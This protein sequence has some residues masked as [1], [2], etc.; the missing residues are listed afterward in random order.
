MIE[1]NLRSIGSII[2]WWFIFFAINNIGLNLWLLLV[3]KKSTGVIKKH[4]KRVILT[5]IFISACLYGASLICNLQEDKSTIGL[6]IVTFFF[7]MAFIM[8]FINLKQISRIYLVIFIKFLL[9]VL[10]MNLLII[11]TYDYPNFMTD[12]HGGYYFTIFS[13]QA[14][15]SSVILCF[16]YSIIF[17]SEKK[18]NMILIEM[19]SVKI[20]NDEEVCSICLDKLNSEKEVIKT[21]CDHVYHKDCLT[22]S[23]NTSNSCPLCR[24]RID[25]YNLC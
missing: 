13:N 9:L 19:T 23:I 2:K 17:F 21:K 24:R 10:C 25:Y 5:I 15:N 7:Y 22:V 11:S 6:S 20:E 4:T 14:S 12:T 8:V 3:F 1:E 16:L 18:E